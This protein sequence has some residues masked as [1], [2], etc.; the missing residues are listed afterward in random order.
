MWPERNGRI[1]MTL[2]KYKIISADSHFIE[3]PD[4]FT[5]RV[6]AK[7][8]DSAP[9]TEMRPAGLG[10]FEGEFWVA[11]GSANAEARPVATYWGAGLS[12][13]EVKEMNKQGYAAAPDFV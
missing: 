3:P 4:V 9:R 5:S 12:M 13:A 10:G 11:P 7:F 8:R 6:S 1:P 2:Q